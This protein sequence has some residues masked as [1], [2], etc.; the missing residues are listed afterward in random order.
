M[1]VAS[2]V[3]RDAEEP[4]TSRLDAIQSGADGVQKSLLHELAADLAI[5]SE[6]HQE[7]QNLR[8]R[9]SVE[10]M[11]SLLRRFVDVRPLPIT[12]TGEGETGHSGAEYTIENSL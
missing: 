9:R 3:R 12:T 2:Q 1:S 4:S 5:A 11:P 8:R 7:P 6:L 10:L